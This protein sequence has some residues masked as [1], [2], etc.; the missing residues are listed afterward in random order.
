MT[1]EHTL[2]LAAAHCYRHIVVYS[3]LQWHCLLDAQ[4]CLPLSG[5]C[6]L[7][8]IAQSDVCQT[9]SA[10]RLLLPFCTCW[11]T[12]RVTWHWCCLL[13]RLCVGGR[14]PPSRRVVHRDLCKRSQLLFDTCGHLT[15]IKHS[16]SYFTQ[17]LFSA[18]LTRDC[19]SDWV[20]VHAW[21]GVRAVCVWMSGGVD[22]MSES[23][24]KVINK[25]VSKSVGAQE[26]E[27]ERDINIVKSVCVSLSVSK[28][29]VT[30]LVSRVM[31][32]PLRYWCCCI[33]QGLVS[34]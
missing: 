11:A 2:Y 13:L 9:L 19:P 10:T 34:K 12:L 21:R 30:T 14:A 7:L 31:S 27:K 28:N 5:V 33:L 16:Y 6:Q 26:N 22:N 23:V 3:E 8:F 4:C 17:D 32:Q 1:T 24:S 20:R 25:S 18:F 15:N 29:Q